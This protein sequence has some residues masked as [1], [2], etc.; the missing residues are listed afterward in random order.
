MPVDMKKKPAEK[1]S[2]VEHTD[3]TRKSTISHGKEDFSIEKAK[4][5]KHYKDILNQKEREIQKL[6]GTD[7]IAILEKEKT[8]LEDKLER[9]T[10]DVDGYMD[11]C[12]D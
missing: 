4:I 2:L 3:M 7:R 1:A 11:K 10:L 12:E 8:R 9:M 5:E 6:K